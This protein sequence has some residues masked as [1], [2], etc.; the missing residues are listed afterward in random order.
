MKH[1][2]IIDKA[3]VRGEANGSFTELDGFCLAEGKYSPEEKETFERE[4]S[5]WIIRRK[6]GRQFMADSD[7]GEDAYGYYCGYFDLLPENAVFRNGRLVGYYLFY[8][9]LRYSGRGRYD[10]SI[11]DW[12]Y[13]GFDRF[14]EH[15]WAQG[16]HLFLFDDENT[17]EYDGWELFKRE[18]GAE[19]IDYLKF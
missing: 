12:G 13:P 9:Y 10:F 16:R 1:A 3:P 8:D 2:V 4:A 18:E 14:K 6:G 5:G 19:Y 7:S 11:D 17:H 15:S